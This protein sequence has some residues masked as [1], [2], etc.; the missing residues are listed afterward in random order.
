LASY[1]ILTLD[2]KKIIPEIV[3]LSYPLEEILRSRKWDSGLLCSFLRNENV[4]I[5]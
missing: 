2:D 4:L 5:L 1:V 3:Q